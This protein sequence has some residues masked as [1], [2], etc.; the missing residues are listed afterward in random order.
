MLHRHKALLLSMSLGV[1]FLVQFYNFDW[2]MGFYGSYMYTLSLKLPIL[3]R[4]WANVCV[5][6][7]VCVCVVCV[8]VQSSIC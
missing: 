5:Q 3:T 8:Y 2:T 7:C 6:V 1:L 4:P